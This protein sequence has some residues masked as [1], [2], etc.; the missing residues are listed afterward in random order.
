MKDK[1][2][3]FLGGL[4]ACGLVFLLLPYTTSNRE[5]TPE[6]KIDSLEESGKGIRESIDSLLVVRSNSEKKR[7]SLVLNASVAIK[8][9]DSIIVGLSDSTKLDSIIKRALYEID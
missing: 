3:F 7:D 6:S 8:R 1:A 9:I 4:I 5:R 2:V